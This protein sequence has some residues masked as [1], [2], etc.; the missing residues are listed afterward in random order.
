MKNWIV[1]FLLLA[2]ID[3]FSQTYEFANGEISFFEEA[4]VEDIAAK[5]YQITSEFDTNTGNITFEVPMESFVFNKSLM[6]QHFNEKYIESDKYPTAK[7]E[8]V[9]KGFDME[10]DGTQSVEAAG[11]MTIHGITRQMDIKGSLNKSGDVLKLNSVFIAR[12]ED[13]KIKI[14]K[15]FWNPVAEQVEITVVIDYKEK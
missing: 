14:P 8:G 13:Y 2:S 10:K 15:L 1:F 3:G 11:V 12:F 5:S 7:F 6:K 9:V 4:S